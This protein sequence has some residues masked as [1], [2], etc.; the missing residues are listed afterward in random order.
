[1]SKGRKNKIVGQTGEYLVA[2]EL[3][4]RGLICTTFTGNVPHYDLIASNEAGEHVSVQVKASMSGS[5]QF[6]NVGDYCDI[7]FK[8]TQQVVGR[9][10]SCPIKNLVVVFVKI[11]KNRL[12]EFFVLTW[13]ELRALIIAN[14]KS[15]LAKHAGVRPKNHSS[16]HVG[17]R[18]EHLIRYRDNWGVVQTRLS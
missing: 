18:S 6:A 3:S 8:G 4:R 11:D 10:K 12:D 1:M 15:Y 16:L 14:H 17:L 2:A 9:H 7:E 13:E 5:W